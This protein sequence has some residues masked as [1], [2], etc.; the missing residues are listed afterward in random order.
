MVIYEYTTTSSTTINGY[1]LFGNRCIPNQMNVISNG[2]S[3]APEKNGNDVFLI[4]SIQNPVSVMSTIGDI[5]PKLDHVI[6]TIGEI[7]RYRMSN[8]GVAAASL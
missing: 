5:S 6:V 7:S 8:Q 3:G 1:P 2:S 4:S